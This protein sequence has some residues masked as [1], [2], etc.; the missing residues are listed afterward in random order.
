MASI[1]VNGDS[2]GAV[3]LSAP[4]VAGTVTVTLPTTSGTM[5]TTA[6]STGVSG[7]AISSG[8]VAEAYGG[9]GT[10]TGYYGFKNRIINGAM[11]IDQRW[12]GG[13]VTDSTATNPYTV[14][15][16]SFYGNVASKVSLQQNQGSVTPPV[17]FT[18]YMGLTVTSAYT[19]S[20]GDAFRF[21]QII[22]GY[23]I[24]DLAWGTANAKTVT[25]SFWAYSSLT[26]T[27]SG[28][29]SN[30]GLSRSYPF[31]FTISSA[32]TW[33]YKTVT[34][35]G[36]T[37]GTWGTTN[38]IGIRLF[39]NMGCGSTTLGTAGAWANAFY[40]GA[41]GSVT[42]VANASATFKFTGVQLEKGSTATSFDYRPYGTEF[43]LCERYYQLGDGYVGSAYSTSGY[44]ANFRFTTAMRTS[45]TVGETGVNTITYPGNADYTQSS[46]SIAINGGSRVSTTA[47]QIVMTN[48]SG[49]VVN[50]FVLIH[51]VGSGSITLS[52][53]L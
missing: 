45:P 19:P 4:A 29:L 25:I 46:V 50:T 27:H 49:L 16:W 23:N 17:G 36:C 10:S 51:N 44:V 30:D 2:S 13:A 41:T 24:A 3:T 7:S 12:A 34:I 20:A 37:D 32:N 48:F 40:A 5:L 52:A 47:V 42:V 15:R 21:Q 39:F 1:V 43:S 53:E 31:T 35:A 14:D 9:T 22:E 38:G 33:E 8:T 18:N 11:V 28:A 6:S 26:G